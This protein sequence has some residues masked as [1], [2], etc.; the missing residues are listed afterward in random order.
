MS[1]I[2][3]DADLC[4]RDGA[5][6]SE[7]PS[8]ILELKPGDSVPHSVKEAE[9][10]C[11]DCGH[12]VAVCPTGAL[13][14]RT[15]TPSDCLPVQPDLLPGLESTERQL[16]ARRSI[17]AFQERAVP[18]E[19]LSRLLEIA[20]HAPTASNSQT[21]EWMVYHETEGVRRIAGQVEDWMRANASPNDLLALKLA[22]EHGADRIC[23]GAPHLVFAHVPKGREGDGMIALTYLEIAAFSAG[24]GACWAG[25]VTAASRVWAPLQA[26]LNLPEGRVL[27]GGLLL[28][29]PRYRYHRIP[30]RKALRAEWR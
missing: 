7:C 28:G 11:I 23:R 5:C 20:R 10:R 12:C 22:E 16:F 24:V 26:E 29:Y 8:Y 17:R 25:F 13:S 4:A 2:V 1:L 14:L 9:E 27:A 21:V 6:V 15:T 18:K 30:P 3:V 19:T